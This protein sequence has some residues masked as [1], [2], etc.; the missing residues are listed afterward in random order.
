MRFDAVAAIVKDTPHTRPYRGRVLYDFV[1]TSGVREML[2]LGFAHGVSTCYFAAALDERGDG[3]IVTIDNQTAKQRKPSISELLEQT[4]LGRYVEPRF[5]N[6]SYT[7]ELMR[8]VEQQTR[9]GKCHP[10]FDFCFVD[11]AHLWDVDGFAFFLVEKLLKPGG[12]ILFDDLYWTLA[13]GMKGTEL[14]KQHLDEEQQTAQVER[15]FSLLVCQHPNFEN[16]MI[17]DSWGWAQKK[18]HASS[19]AS[20]NVASAVYSRQGI[21]SDLIAIANKLRWRRAIKRA[22]ERSR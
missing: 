18:Q 16:M 10:R 15:I 7:W 1:L 9:E 8:L 14:A 11:G 5:V 17:R 13:Q 4:G 3:T 22:E 2:E 6:R 12:W 20:G 19:E 21:V